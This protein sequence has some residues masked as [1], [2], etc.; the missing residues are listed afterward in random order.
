MTIRTTLTLALL[1]V[2]TGT[3][4]YAQTPS[5]LGTFRDWSAYSYTDQRGKVCFVA[6]Q[7]KD[8]E[9]KGVN[10]D[11]TFFMVTSRPVESVKHEARSKKKC[12]STQ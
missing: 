5:K 9:P 11:P 3:T 8:T 2:A 10:R 1:I 4:A 6:S 7:P 12:G